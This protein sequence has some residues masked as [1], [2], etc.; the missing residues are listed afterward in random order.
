V[1]TRPS[2]A[3]R[4]STEITSRTLIARFKDLEVHLVG[5]AQAP[6]TLEQIGIIREREFRRAGAGRGMEVDVDRFDTK[7]P[8]YAQIVSWDPDR[9][10]IVAMYRAIHCGWAVRRGGLDAL[11]THQLFSFSDEFVRER[12]VRSVELGRSVVNSEARRAIQGLFSVWVGLGAL[13]REWR[14]VAFFFGNVSIYRSL[15]ESAVS[16]VIGYLAGN[17]YAGSGYVSARE[18]TP[19]WVPGPPIS[20]VDPAD[21]SSAL[22]DLESRAAA[23]GWMVP[24]IL[25]SYLKAHPGLLAFDAAVDSDFGGAIEVAIAVPVEGLSS[26]TWDRFIAPYRSVNPD[27]FVLTDPVPGTD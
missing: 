15:P 4:I 18:R 21:R 19:W 17:H 12:L 10:E 14:D 8:A 9:G 22:R 23:E 27:R 7:D 20:Q 2:I 26:K 1:T 25:L 13:V 11:R 6:A 24:P 3:H 5:G 16:A